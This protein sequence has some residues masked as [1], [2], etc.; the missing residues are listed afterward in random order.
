MLCDRTNLLSGVIV[1]F[2][3]RKSKLNPKELL[4]MSVWHFK[5]E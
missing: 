5:D 3:S 2:Q 4:I 1:M